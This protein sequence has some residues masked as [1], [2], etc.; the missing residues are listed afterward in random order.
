MVPDVANHR[1]FRKYKGVRAQ[2]LRHTL[3]LTSLLSKNAVC[4]IYIIAKCHLEKRQCYFKYTA[5]KWT[6]FLNKFQ[7]NWKTTPNTRHIYKKTLEFIDSISSKQTMWFA[8][9]S[10]ENVFSNR[11]KIDFTYLWIKFDKS[12]DII[13]NQKIWNQK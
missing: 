2:C 3:L 12:T 1:G 7:E 13:K 10:Q 5:S 4:D 11:E 9:G 6:N 8:T